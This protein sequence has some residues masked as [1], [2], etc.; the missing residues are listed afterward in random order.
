MTIEP[1]PVY[2]MVSADRGGAILRETPGGKPITALDNFTYVQLLPETQAVS[3]YTWS[4]VIASPNGVPLKGWVVQLYLMT[5]TPNPV[6][7]PATTPA[8]AATATP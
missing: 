7:E 6:L 4:H 2:V 3:G 5:A 1:T 8:P